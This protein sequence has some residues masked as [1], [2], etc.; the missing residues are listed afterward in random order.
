MAELAVADGRPPPGDLPRGQCII[1]R[2][3]DLVHGPGLHI[4]HADPRVLISAPV[5][6]E[7]FLAP[8]PGVSLNTDLLRQDRNGTPFWEGAVLKIEGVNRT[9]IYRVGAYLP[10]IDGYIG[11]WPD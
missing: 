10:R 7:A 6:G 2:T 1:T 8:A 9:V 5:L 4:D 3:D 11:E